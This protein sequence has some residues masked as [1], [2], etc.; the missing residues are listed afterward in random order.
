MSETLQN[1]SIEA[2]IGETYLKANQ[3][4]KSRNRITIV[5]TIT[6]ERENGEPFQVSTRCDCAVSQDTQP[7]QRE[8]TVTEEWKP[9]DLGWAVEW[10]DSGKP[11]GV[12]SIHHLG[13]NRLQK[14]PTETER[15]ETI[16]R[17]LYIALGSDSREIVEIF[18]R[19]SFRSVLSDA[20]WVKI[21]AKRGTVRALVTIFPG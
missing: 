13:G 10:L 1:G 17:T 16:S 4:T 6:Y 21:R 3:P 15:L 11:I 8:I 19:D 5:E 14:V 18:P 2:A 9:I 20:R 7:Y 12:I